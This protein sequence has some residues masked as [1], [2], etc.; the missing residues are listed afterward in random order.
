MPIEQIAGE[1][2]IEVA[3]CA[4]CHVAD[5]Y[6][7]FI[8]TK[9]FTSKVP[10]WNSIVLPGGNLEFDRHRLKK[11]DADHPILNH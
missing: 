6:P 10:R 3:E 7:E 11:P 1:T 8:S 5:D 9:R 4:G 2:P